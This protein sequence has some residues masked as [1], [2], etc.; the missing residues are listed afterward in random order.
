MILTISGIILMFFGLVVSIVFWVPG[1][2]NR[3]R[4]RSIM[5]RR[6]PLV[7][8]VYIANGPMLILFGLLL[9]IWPKV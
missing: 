9:I 6:Y 4:I 5:G 8:V 3:N 1:I 2:I 7:Y